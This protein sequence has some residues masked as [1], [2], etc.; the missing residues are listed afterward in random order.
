VSRH[1]NVCRPL[2]N[3]PNKE[4]TMRNTCKTLFLAI[5]SSLAMTLL[6]TGTVRAENVSSLRIGLVSSLFRDTPKSVANVVGQALKTLMEN[7]TGMSGEL[8]ADVD[9]VALAGLLNDKQL[10][11]AVFHGFEFAWAKQKHP[12]LQP[13]VVVSNPNR[14]QAYLVVSKTGKIDSVAALQGKA[15]T[16]P[17]RMPEYGHL[18]LERRCTTDGKAPKEFYKITRSADA[19]DA[20][21][22]V[23]DGQAQAALID[24]TRLELFRK[25]KPERYAQLKVLAQSE[26][27]PAAVIAYNASAMSAENTR[28]LR[29]AMLGMGNQG[30]GKEFLA[31]CQMS[32]FAVV[33]GDFEQTLLTIAKA[34]PAPAAK[35]GF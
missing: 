3:N 27:F 24:H 17:R 9:A 11:I 18:F 8:K 35:Q 4:T 31:M 12:D 26:A 19:D 32:G 10:D 33:P 25:S 14:A 30:Q 23:L 28:A 6:P 22:D 16:M 13:L 20:L 7:Q 29:T 21:E 5:L 1:N 34:Y 2:K 15:L